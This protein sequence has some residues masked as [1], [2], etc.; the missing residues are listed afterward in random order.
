VPELSVVVPTLNEAAALPSLLAELAQQT[1]IALEVLVA[2]GGSSDASVAVAERAG[3][4]VV[5]AP[6]GRGAQMNAAA[7]VARGEY[8]LFLHADSGLGSPL[9]LR[10]ALAAL[11]QEIAARGANAAGHFPLRFARSSDAHA[12]FYR[13]LEEKTAINRPDTINGDQGTLLAAAHFRALGGFDERL[14]FLEDQRLAAKIFAQGRWI[15]L[16]G[17]LITSARRFESE[18]VYRRYTLMAIMMGMHASGTDAF[19]A[20]ARGVYASQD[21]AR[22]LDVRPYCWLVRTLLWETRWRGALGISLRNGRYVRSQSWQLF[23]WCDLLLRPLLGPGRHPFLRFHDRVVH[24]LTA[25]VVA[26]AITG[27]FVVLWFVFLLPAGYTLRE[28]L[29]G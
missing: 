19:F 17:R 24:P 13:G 2:D 6:R 1:G 11:R 29:R 23:F 26:D 27:A 18:G 5:R 9:L 20:R 16:P 8:L 4:R 22:E 3:A 21:Q 10:D 25:H 7:A 28:R 15:V 14:P 12:F